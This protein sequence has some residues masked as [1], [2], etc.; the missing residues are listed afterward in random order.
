MGRRNTSSVFMGIPSPLS[1]TLRNLKA[2]RL[3]SI[4][5]VSLHSARQ[6]P[7]ER[8]PHFSVGALQ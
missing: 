6:Y 1:A 3:C 8:Q 4:A 7:A 2:H 5:D